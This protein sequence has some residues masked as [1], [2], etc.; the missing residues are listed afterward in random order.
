MKK[1]D[2]YRI[3]LLREKLQRNSVFCLLLWTQTHSLVNVFASLRSQCY[4]D[5]N[6]PVNGSDPQY[7]LCA[8]QL[9]SHMSAVTSTPT[10]M[11]RN[12]ISFSMS[13]G[14]PGNLTAS[15][16]QNNNL[17][18]LPV[19]ICGC[20]E[21]YWALPGLFIHSK[22]CDMVKTFNKLAFIGNYCFLIYYFTCFS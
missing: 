15:Q 22:C 17:S 14:Q 1:S 10:C 12:S 2:L 16:S 7:P 8:M 19:P 5:H 11:R 4:M 9:S 20:F 18:T 21:L 3:S 6:R 13:N